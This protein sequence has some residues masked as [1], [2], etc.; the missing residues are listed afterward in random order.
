MFRQDSSKQ[1]TIMIL[2][3]IKVSIMKILQKHLKKISNC[4]N[5]RNLLN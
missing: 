4:I 5:F 2:V 1:T 3:K